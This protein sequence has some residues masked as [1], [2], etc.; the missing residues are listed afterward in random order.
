MDDLPSRLLTRTAALAHRLVTERFAE[1]GARGYHYRLLT[2]LIDDGPA[3][4]ADLGRR[5][6]IHFS[7]MVAA[8]NELAE[9]GYVQR[10]PDPA[11]RRRNIVT[12]TPQGRRRARALAER[13]EQIQDELLAP[14]SATERGELVRLLRLVSAGAAPE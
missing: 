14:L 5:T 6:E 2:T 12:V 1:I 13:A 3:S 4:Q 11:D 10:R 9:D 8:L 7:D